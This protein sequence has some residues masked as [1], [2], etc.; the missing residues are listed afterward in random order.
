MKKSFLLFTLLSAFPAFADYTEGLGYFDNQQY[1]QALAEFKP[2]ADK[3]H[4]RAQYYVGYM[5]LNGYGVDR[6]ETLGLKYIQ[7]SV[8]GGFEKAESLMGYFLS[9][10][11]YVPQ[12][13]PKG[14]KLYQQAAEKGDD[15]ALLNLGVAYYLGGGVEQ[16]FDKAISYLSKV[17]VVNK[18]IAA[19]YLA[20]VYLAQGNAENSKKAPDLYRL[21]AANGD[22][23][24]FHFYASL[25]QQG[26]VVDANIDEAVK[27][28][29]YAASQ[30]YAPSQYVLGTL[31]AN[32]SVV[33]RDVYKGYAWISL[34]ANQN[35]KLALEAQ[36]KLEEDMTLSD[37]D[38]ARREMVKLQTDVI[39]HVESPLEQAVLHN[40][41]V[42]VTGGHNNQSVNNGRRLRPRR[43]R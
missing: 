29:T 7:K 38:K 20:D 16:D 12:N 22:L 43:R 14:L 35:F 27:Y 40:G 26:K 32:G 4:D 23:P 18:P 28:Y 5:Y 8:D 6:D 3:G 34:A 9:E 31:Y 25:K 15:D 30:S 21:A 11:L 17:N 24:S 42:L 2:L 19:R 37:L 39:G 1:P 36:K 33:S 41:S 10:G 13:K